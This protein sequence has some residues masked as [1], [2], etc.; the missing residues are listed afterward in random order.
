MGPRQI[1]LFTSIE[2]CGG[3]GA[4]IRRPV[5]EYSGR[6]AFIELLLT[7]H[8]EPDTG[9]CLLQLL[10]VTKTVTLKRDLDELVLF[11]ASTDPPA[12]RWPTR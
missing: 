3:P 12:R 10:G 4:T 9:G 6:R 11:D 5:I 2:Y 7:P 8:E 1:R